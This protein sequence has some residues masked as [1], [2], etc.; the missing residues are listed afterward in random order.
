MAVAYSDKQ[1]SDDL[2][3]NLVTHTV[4]RIESYIPLH[5]YHDDHV[6]LFSKKY[7]IKHDPTILELIEI[8]KVR[9]GS[10]LNDLVAPATFA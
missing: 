9:Y 10:L 8:A 6:N 7:T 1:C 3:I 2:M 5:S 4:R